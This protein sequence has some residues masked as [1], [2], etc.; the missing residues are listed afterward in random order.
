MITQLII[1]LL[2]WFALMVIGTN[3]IGMFVRGLALVSDVENQLSKVDDT[4]KKIAGEIYDP[5]VEK[6]VNFIALAL[7]AVYLITLFYFWN[8]GVVVAAIMLMIARI[9]DLLWEIKHGRQGIKNM[10]K[11]YM[12]TNL[13]MFAALPV[14]WYSLYS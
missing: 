6:K 3:L 8:I 14:L 13:I 2:S 5:K 7:I 1:T 11:R 9:P 10:P 4:I 12:L